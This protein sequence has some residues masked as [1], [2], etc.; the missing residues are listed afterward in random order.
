VPRRRAC[1]RSSGPTASFTET[2]LGLRGTR[3]TVMDGDVRP[4]G[5]GRD[6]ADNPVVAA[7]R[8]VPGSRERDCSH[9]CGLGRDLHATRRGHRPSYD[10]LL[11][12]RRPDWARRAIA[13]PRA[14]SVRCPRPRVDRPRRVR[15]DRA[16]RASSRGPRRA[17][18]RRTRAARARPASGAVDR[19]PARGRPGGHGEQGPPLHS[20]QHRGRALHHAAGPRAARHRHRARRVAA[21][22]ALAGR[23]AR[24][25]PHRP[26]AS[27][28]T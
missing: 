24:A 19:G 16:L 7:G 12:H 22:P 11:H 4:R 26:G 13:S 14:G 2:P 28:S 5:R 25:R 23:A 17:R 20:R 18:G 27:S 10:E 15:P 9:A 6:R 21:A 1:S 8:V 3:A